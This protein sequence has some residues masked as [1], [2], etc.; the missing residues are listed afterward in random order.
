MLQWSWE[1]V[2]SNIRRELLEIALANYTKGLFISASW[3]VS[4]CRSQ[5]LKQTTSIRGEL[6]SCR[7]ATVASLE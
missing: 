3:E 2:F 1:S 6:F 4:G 7:K 5:K